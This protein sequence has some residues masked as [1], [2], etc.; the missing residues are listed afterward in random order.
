MPYE[1]KSWCVAAPDVNLTELERALTFAC[2][3]GNGTC[4]ALTPGK[5]CYEPLSVIW[6]ASFAFS[7][8]WAKFRSQGANCYFNGLAVQTTSDPSESA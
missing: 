6:H 8:Y 1:G 2:S 7:S 4:E 5:E 3:Q